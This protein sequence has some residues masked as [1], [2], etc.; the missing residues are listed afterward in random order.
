MADDALQPRPV[1]RGACLRALLAAAVALFLMFLPGELA[2][3]SPLPK[4]STFGDVDAFAQALRGQGG[5]P[6]AP[7]KLR[8]RLAVRG[9]LDETVAEETAAKR[10]A[11]TEIANVGGIA[12]RFSPS[13][14]GQLIADGWRTRARPEGGFERGR[15]LRSMIEL[16]R[17]L[18]YS[19]RIGALQAQFGTPYELGIAELEDELVAARAAWAAT[20]GDAEAAAWVEELETEIAVIAAAAKPGNGPS[21]R[22]ARADLDVNGDGG[23][24]AA[25]LAALDA[26]QMPAGVMA[27]GFAKRPAGR[28]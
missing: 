7:A 5:D 26:G 25:D 17:R 3:G 14:S 8:Y 9:A 1:S 6:L 15:R 10:I 13:E 20:P 21:A 22:W 4:V 2:A 19:G 23:V 28:R 16:A 27:A 24:D 12:L 11:V 18:G